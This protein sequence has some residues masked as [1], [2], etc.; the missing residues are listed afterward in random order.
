MYKVGFLLQLPQEGLTKF[1][2]LNYRSLKKISEIAGI[3]F[4]CAPPN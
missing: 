1:A 2:Y 3:T 4:Q